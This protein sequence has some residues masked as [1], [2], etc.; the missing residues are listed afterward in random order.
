MGIHISNAQIDCFGRLDKFSLRKAA[1]TKKMCLYFFG[2][3]AL[4]QLAAY[5]LLS[6]V[7]KPVQKNKDSD[8]NSSCPDGDC[9]EFVYY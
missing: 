6:E 7:L 1:K 2:C 5:F 9:S 4:G 8:I 3:V